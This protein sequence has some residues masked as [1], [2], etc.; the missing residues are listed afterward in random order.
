MLHTYQQGFQRDFFGTAL[1][2]TGKT[3][4]KMTIAYVGYYVFVVFLFG[5]VAFSSGIGLDIMG[6]IQ[7]MSDPESVEEIIALFS[8]LFLNP[9]FIIL[10]FAYVILAIILSAW[11]YTYA[12]K[13]GEFEMKDRPY[14]FGSVL[15]A[16]Y[17]KVIVRLILASLLAY[18]ALG[19]MTAIVIGLG[20]LVHWS[21]GVIGFVALIGVLYRWLIVP[22]SIAM[23]N[24]GVVEAFS[25]S[26]KRINFGKAY[27]YFGISILVFIALIIVIGILS[28]IPLILGSLSEIGIIL[29]YVINALSGG[30]ITMFTVSMI[31]GLHMR[32]SEPYGEN[33][34]TINIEDHLIE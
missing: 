34:G 19:F 26:M 16:S 22:A 23:D 18:I 12:F 13:L 6:K 20:S 8:D 28:V 24:K 17:S 11:M 1:K 32:L 21:L 30:V 5:I 15:K 10:G 31:M 27:A 14:T 33:D 2:L 7:N 29:Q 3:W 25:L 9:T 4:L